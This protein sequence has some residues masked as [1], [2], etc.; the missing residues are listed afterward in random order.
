MDKKKRT[1]WILIAALLVVGSIGIGISLGDV[2]IT[3]T[4]T[5]GDG[6]KGVYGKATNTTDVR[7]YGGYFVA[8]GSEGT[9]VYG[10]G[11]KGGYFTTTRAGSL[12]MRPGSYP[13]AGVLVSTAYDF[14]PGVYAHTTGYGSLGVSARTGGDASDGVS[15]YTTGNGSDGVS[16]RTMGDR[17]DGVYVKTTGY[18][19]QGVSAYTTGDGSQGV[20]VNTTGDGSQGVYVNTTGYGSEGVYAH[21]YGDHSSG[22]YALTEGYYSWGVS[23]RTK[24]DGSRGVFAS[25]TGAGSDGVFASTTGAGSYG[26]FA[27]TGGFDSEGVGAYTTGDGSDGVSARTT[28]DGSRG[29]YAHTSGLESPGVEAI[30]T[31]TNS[32]GV[33]ART[34]GPAS[35]GVFASSKFSPGVYG[36]SEKDRGVLGKGETYDFYAAG[37]PGTNYGPFTG[38]HEVKLSANFTENVTP[39]MIVSV[40]GETQVR[41]IDGR[42]ISFS[43]TLPTVQLSG[44]PNDSKVLGVLISESPLPGEHWYINESIEG[45]RFGIVNALG[46]GRVWVTDVNGDIEA[47]EYIT[48][49]L[50]AGYGQKQDDD[51]LHSYTLGK[52]IESVN[53]SEVTTTV[54]FNGQTYMAYPIA[55]VYT[56][57]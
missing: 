11:S 25:T 31:C 39:G 36:A 4:A 30:T 32:I 13:L 26:V 40:T 8:K 35:I 42:N 23:T 43:S 14:N 57:G 5:G 51:L 7:N 55:V 45:D 22:V 2:G 47:G 44:T 20:Y 18:G 6:S 34:R 16:A 24:G 56:S 15:A 10:R 41:Q 38:A 52:A 17:S 33:L 54:E 37:G 12:I 49:S 19:S 3:G 53:W 9:G 29:V 50:V 46:E 27:R 28:G 48:T 1:F 21:T